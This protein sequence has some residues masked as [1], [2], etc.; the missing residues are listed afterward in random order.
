[1]KNLITILL[2]LVSLSSFSQTK[3]PIK[4][5]F[6]GDSV[7]ILTIQ[8]SDNINKMI[9]KNSRAVKENNAK[10]QEYVNRIKALEQTNSE[11]NARIDSLSGVLLKCS[12]NID[13]IQ[14]NA[15]TLLKQYEELNLTIYEMS[16]GPT[17]L[18]TLPPYKEVLFLNLKHFNMYTDSDGTL[19]LERMTPAQMKKY[20]AWREKYGNESLMY[21]DYQRVIRFRDFQDELI[22]RIIWKNKLNYSK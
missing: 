6:K 18:Y 13:T 11:L 1:M 16:V 22:E 9:E 21:I 4:T 19:I 20:D 14:Y 17:L 5:I 7:V 8:Q 15:D 3:Y 12:N 2:L 10:V